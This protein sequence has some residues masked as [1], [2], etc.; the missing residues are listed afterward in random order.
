MRAAR[1]EW[2]R[3]WSLRQSWIILLVILASGAGGMFYRY[4]LLDTSTG[5]IDVIQ[6]PILLLPLV[7]SL[8]PAQAI[9]QEY[10]FGLARNTLTLFP[11][12]LEIFLAK[13]VVPTIVAAAVSAVALAVFVGAAAVSS[14]SPLDLGTTATVLARDALYL[15]V[16]LTIA[17]AVTA[18][19]RQTT[20][21]VIAPFLL[22]LFL[23][24]FLL[25]QALKVDPALLPFASGADFVATSEGAWGSLAVL[26]GYA[27]AVL[28][29]AA[30]AFRWRDA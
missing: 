12:R 19:T 17:F 14:S 27:L 26:A 8:V 13:W 22:S 2:T 29:A 16:Y 1:F 7:A 4:S 6:A 15:V 18:L 20:I 9:G 23:E 21:G 24:R 25:I 30:A 11:L 28:V 5:V 3:L 10:R